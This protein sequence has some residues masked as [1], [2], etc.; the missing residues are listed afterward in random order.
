MSSKSRK[1][2]VE[3]CCA[4]CGAVEPKWASI[5]RGVLLCDQCANIHLTLGRHISQVKHLKKSQWNPMLLEMV[6]SLAQLGAN[7]IWEHSLLDPT[8]A[9]S[10]KR[11]PSPNDPIRPNKEEFITHKYEKLAFV[12]KHPTSSRREEDD[13]GKQLHSSVRTAYLDSSLRLLASGA[14]ANFLHPEKGN[15]PLHV[16]ARSNQKTQVELL[17]VYGAD[18][19][20]P[21]KQGY[22]PE[23]IARME[24]NTEVA[25]RL[26]ELQYELSDRLAYYAC[27]TLPDHK[28]GA[29]FM[30]PRIHQDNQVKDG[31]D[32]L[33]ALNNLIFEELAEDVFDEVDRRESVQMWRNCSLGGARMRK[34]HEYDL[35][36][37]L[38]LN[39]EYSSTRNQGR[40]KLAR[41]T[42]QEFLCLIHDVLC[43]IVRRNSGKEISG[44]IMDDPIYDL[45]PDYEPT[46]ENEMPSIENKMITIPVDE[47]EQLVKLNMELGAKDRHINDL[48]KDNSIL[49]SRLTQFANQLKKNED[50][51]NNLKRRINMTSLKTGMENSGSPFKPVGNFD[52]PN[53]VI[54]TGMIGNNTIKRNSRQPSERR[55]TV[56]GMLDNNDDHANNTSGE[57]GGNIINKN[58]NNLLLVRDFP[59]IDPYQVLSNIRDGSKLPEY[60]E[61]EITST[62]VT[63]EIKVMYA[64]VC[65]KKENYKVYLE[66]IQKS[67]NKVICLFPQ[68]LVEEELLD[69]L[70]KYYT[71]STRLTEPNEEFNKK[72]HELQYKFITERAYAVAKAQKQLLLWLLHQNQVGGKPS[73]MS[74]SRS[75]NSTPHD[76]ISSASPSNQ[77]Q[78]STPMASPSPSSNQVPSNNSHGNNNQVATSSPS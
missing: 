51:I 65:K 11:K 50:E 37:F 27:K 53:S 38:K 48:K 45:P 72:Q 58:N 46:S 52:R 7:A 9:K 15:T 26:V 10:G 25:D 62:L 77:Q 49:T 24:G 68:K 18:P 56:I 44:V 30:I 1:S 42:E 63:K 31:K 59:L 67:V 8:H 5:N 34:K 57:E 4:D 29:H 54:N 12:N 69:L 75:Q 64:T 13:L 71:A 32:K 40:Q 36:P 20:V 60:K 76:A 23:Q 70:K 74:P 21:N 61:V 16:A 14:N 73:S 66:N 35:P 22:S 41:F 39:N 47:Y 19:M 55:Q 6:K 17:V 3:I 33:K 43:D 28:S 2:H 78:Q